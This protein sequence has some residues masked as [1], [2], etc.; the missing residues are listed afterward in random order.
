MPEPFCSFSD[1][2][3]K[4]LQTMLQFSPAS[5]RIAALQETF[6]PE[7]RPSQRAGFI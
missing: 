4:K 6:P 2:C 5:D 7:T 1:A 3:Q